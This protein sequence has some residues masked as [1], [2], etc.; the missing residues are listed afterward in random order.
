MRFAG[1]LLMEGRPL[2]EEGLERKRWNEQ[3]KIP[4]GI[5][6]DPSKL[7]VTPEL[8]PHPEI[9]QTPGIDLLRDKYIR[10]DPRSG[11]ALLPG[12]EQ[13]PA[14]GPNIPIKMYDGRYMP[15]ATQPTGYRP[16]ARA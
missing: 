7:E 4:L 11:V 9:R 12:G 2:T 6:L 16:G 14:Q 15:D 13:G 1:D 3:Q 5:Q 10:N 8:T